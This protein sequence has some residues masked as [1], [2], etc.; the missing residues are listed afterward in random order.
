[1]LSTW[2]SCL[3]VHFPPS[4]LWV[5]PSFTPILLLLQISLT[6]GYVSAE[7][8]DP[9]L[10]IT[11]KKQKHFSLKSRERGA[12]GQAPLWVSWHPKTHGTPRVAAAGMATVRVQGSPRSPL[13]PKSPADHVLLCKDMVLGPSFAPHEVMRLQRTEALERMLQ[14]HRDVR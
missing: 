13:L 3:E 10:H 1:M 7:A 14:A 4:L 2:V 11:P 12:Q 5:H 9:P 6:E 8:A